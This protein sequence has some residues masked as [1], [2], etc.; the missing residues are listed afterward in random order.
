[1]FFYS[2]FHKRLVLINM[3]MH[4][5]VMRPNNLCKV[6]VECIQ[7]QNLSNLCFLPYK[8]PS[9]LETLYELFLNRLRAA[10]KVYLT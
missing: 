3:S 1:M 6:F 10:N 9:A 7:R 5:S 8:S 4:I 2:F